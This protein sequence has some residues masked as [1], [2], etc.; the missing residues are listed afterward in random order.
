M[1]YQL[2]QFHVME[3]GVLACG[4]DVISFRRLPLCE[5]SFFFWNRGIPLLHT[6]CREGV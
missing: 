3:A 6:Y 4:V 5:F 1:A 2:W